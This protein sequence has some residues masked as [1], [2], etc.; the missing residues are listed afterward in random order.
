MS[1]FSGRLGL[2]L[3]D[4][5]RSQ[6]WL[7]RE[8]GLSAAS[9]GLWVR[10]ARWLWRSHDPIPALCLGRRGRHHPRRNVRL[11]VVEDTQAW[12]DLK[13]GAALR[14]L[15]DT[16]G[17][18]QVI[19]DGEAGGCTVQVFVAWSGEDCRGDWFHATGATIAEAADKCREALK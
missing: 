5:G 3:R 1:A 7:A 4:N 10:G 17:V 12:R 15:R 14:G 16:P 11:M 2:L 6:R 9:V 19:I 18:T 13:D 8:V